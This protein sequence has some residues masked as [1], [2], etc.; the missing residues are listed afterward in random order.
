[1]TLPFIASLVSH[2]VCFVSS[3]RPLKWLSQRKEIALFI[4]LLMHL[5]STLATALADS[6]QHWMICTWSQ[7]LDIPSVGLLSIPFI[8]CCQATHGLLLPGTAS[9]RWPFP[10]PA[11]RDTHHPQFHHDCPRQEQEPC[12]AA[13][14]G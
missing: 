5:T 7:F 3:L 11:G 4:H 12:K 9:W 10:V 1:M 6:S 14:L 8:L 13:C 2:L